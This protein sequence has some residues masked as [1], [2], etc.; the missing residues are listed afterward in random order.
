MTIDT[1]K[2]LHETHKEQSLYG[3][4]VNSGN[5]KPL[6]EKYA[7]KF[8]IETIGESVLGEDIYSITVGT[9]QKKILIW[10]QM[11]GNES[12]TTKAVFDVL[13]AFVSFNPLYDHILKGCTI[14]VI[15][16][17]NPDGAN[18][19]TRL[20]ANN[21][22]LNRDAQDLTQPESKVLKSCF[23]LFKPDYCFNLH[24]QRTIFSA[25]K[26]EKVAT[27]S[28]LAPAQDDGCTITETRKVA[29][30]IIVKMNEMLQQELP[31][32]V[33]IYDDA[34]N[35]NCVGDAFQSLNV[36]TV[37]FEAGHYANDYDREEVRR[38]IF[39]SLMV[40]INA[41]VKDDID[42]NDVDAYLGIPQNDKLFY[43]IIVR[44]ANFNGKT[45]DIAIQYQERLM[46]NVLQF[47]PKIVKIE[48]LTEYFGH[49]TIDAKNNMV[50]SE[51]NEVVK[52]EDENDF[53]VV[54]NVK[55]SLKIMKS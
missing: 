23:E 36:P 21:V 20:N 18:A 14:K 28:F 8:Q 48:K 51:E 7:D 16:I 19:Y 44:N 29:M 43:D 50:L 41:I 11:H 26:Q 39:Q 37:L 9:G 22:D 5:I 34:F 49:K 30:S 35:M 42:V 54:D 40:A 27:V 24:G 17:L 25:G 46:D 13:N 31:N 33:G 55:L 3:R 15:P 47:I 38:Y 53:V 32:Q 2:A 12:T 1:L 10:S 4:Y 52:L 6:F 45:L